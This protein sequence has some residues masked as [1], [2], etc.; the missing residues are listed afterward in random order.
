MPEISL[1]NYGPLP[2]RNHH[3]DLPAHKQ[4]AALQNNKQTSGMNIAKILPDI[5]MV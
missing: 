2:D 3:A 4:Q 5:K 1:G